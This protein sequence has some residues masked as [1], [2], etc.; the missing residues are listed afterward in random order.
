MNKLIT[1]LATVLAAAALLTGC[2]STVPSTQDS[3]GID[4]TLAD[5]TVARTDA[6][7][8]VYAE[9]GAAA[10]ELTLGATTRFGSPR[11]LLVRDTAGDGDWLQVLVPVRPNDRTGWIRS[12]DVSL[13]RFDQLIHVDTAA[14]TLTVVEAGET[15]LSV[16]AAVGAEDS[17]TPTGLFSVVDKLENPDPSDAYGPYAIGLSSH[18]DVY[19]EFAGGDGQIGIHGTNEPDS[20]G[21]A[22]SHGCIRVSNDIVT[23][24]NGR[25]HLGAPVMVV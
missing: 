25:I 11:A 24:L 22:V 7:L 14:R 13:E 6:A 3:S 18:S 12:T 1:L 19:Q 10:P 2:G 21:E 16:P 5:A 15:V 9:P 17:V 23:E 20:I 8:D 4:V